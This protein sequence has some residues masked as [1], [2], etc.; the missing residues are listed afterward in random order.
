MPSGDA[1]RVGLG[2]AGDLVGSDGTDV[3]YIS[4]PYG[5]EFFLFE[6]AAVQTITG[7]TQTDIINSSANI[8]TTGTFMVEFSCSWE[9]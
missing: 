5:Q 1:Q 7:T 9:R 3:V 8:L 2:A 4:R 6:N